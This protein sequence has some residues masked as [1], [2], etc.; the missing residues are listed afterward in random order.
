MGRQSLRSRV[1]RIRHHGFHHYYDSVGGGRGGA[2]QSESVRARFAEGSDGSDT[3]SS[4][5][6]GH[7][8]PQGIQGSNRNRNFSSGAVP[9]S[10]RSHNIGRHL[11]PLPPARVVSSLEAG[12]G[13]ASSRQSMA[14]DWRVAAAISQ[15]GAWA[16]RL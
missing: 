5:L 12:S 4:L 14:D 7:S 15:V 2:L 10:K 6:P 11:G 9:G 3:G 8:F 16:L 1:A 13:G